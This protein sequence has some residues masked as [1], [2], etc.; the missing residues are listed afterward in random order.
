MSGE[1][2]LVIFQVSILIMSVVIH[3]VS[4]GFMALRLGDPTAKYAD[5][6]TF[7]PVKHF[8]LWGSFIVPFFMIT[9]FNFGFGWAKPVPY[10]PYNLRDQKLGP[11]WVALAGPASNIITAIIFAIGA[12]IIPLS[13][14]DKFD[15]IINMFN[16]NELGFLLSG[17]F[18]AIFFW[19]F[20][21][22][23]TINIFL[24]IFNLIPIPPLDGSKLLF[25]FAPIS[26]QKKMVLEQYGFVFLLFI[27]FF[28][29]APIWQLMNFVLSLFFRFL[30]GVG[31]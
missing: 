4:H 12:R 3:E 5:R 25:A 15:I 6:L 1:I 9:F 8:D 26:E 21:M 31:I 11:A 28:L 23:L 20:V 2:I 14:G 22:I 29:S 13:Y 30:V 24:A 17:S 19:L 7:N 10:N 16:F 18:T 27:I